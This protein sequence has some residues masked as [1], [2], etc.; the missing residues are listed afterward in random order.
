MATLAIMRRG[1]SNLFLASIVA[2]LLM[3]V[4]IIDGIVP[5]DPTLAFPAKLLLL[6]GTVLLRPLDASPDL[7]II[8]FASWAFYTAVL[9]PIVSLLSGS[10]LA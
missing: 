9:W 6:P 8:V 10:R 5:Y 1:S 4:P 3:A 2:L 7:P